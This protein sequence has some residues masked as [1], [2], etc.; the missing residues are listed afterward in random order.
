MFIDNVAVQIEQDNISAQHHLFRPD[1]PTLDLLMASYICPLAAPLQ[2][3]SCADF[4]SSERPGLPFAPARV[5]LGSFLHNTWTV[6]AFTKVI[7]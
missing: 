3:I 7:L 1:L 6:A 2:A 5:G 4:P